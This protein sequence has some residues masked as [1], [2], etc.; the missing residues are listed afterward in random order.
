MTEEANNSSNPTPTTTL[1][2]PVD[3]GVNP[4][5][6]SDVLDKHRHENGKILGKFDAPDKLAEAYL[7]LEKESTKTRQEMKKLERKAPDSYD[8]SLDES[9]KDR[10]Q[11]D[12][13]DPRLA[14]FLPKFKELNLQTNEVKALINTW[15]QAE[16]ED[17]EK[18]AEEFKALAAENPQLIKDLFSFAEGLPTDEQDAYKSMVQT[19]EQAKVLHRILS[20]ARQGGNIPAAPK[21]TSSSGKSKQQLLDE[22]F[23]YRDT[24]NKTISSN[25][26]QQ[27][28]FFRLLAL[29]QKAS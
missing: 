10:W 4:A 6:F 12:E 21:D 27:D 28:E 15:V 23:A 22:A 24:N 19:P 9:L 13:N 1:N 26:G 25:K 11:I 20:A 18:S 3:D 14:R 7:S 29:A 2:E 16:L 8:L 17:Y 5:K